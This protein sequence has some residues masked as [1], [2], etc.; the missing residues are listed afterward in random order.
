MQQHIRASPIQRTNNSL[1]PS[2]NGIARSLTALIHMC[3]NVHS[4][5]T[6]SMHQIT[7]TASIN[8]LLIRYYNNICCLEVTFCDVQW[9]KRCENRKHFIRS[10]LIFHGN[11]CVLLLNTFQSFHRS[12]CHV[13][14]IIP[15]TR[16]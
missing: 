11:V 15:L 14:I 16:S 4:G 8:V 5:N 2:A 12:P 10:I 1:F 7:F 3:R 9:L 13:I 6:F